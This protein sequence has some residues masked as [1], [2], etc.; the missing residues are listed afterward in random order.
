MKSWR[1]GPKYL[2][3]EQSEQVAQKGGL[4]GPDARQVTAFER[5]IL[6]GLQHKPVY[7]G[8]VD[9]VVVQQRRT[10]NRAGRR[11]RRI[12]RLAAKR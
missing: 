4:A 6:V 8:T 9:P 10:R 5:S 11:S 3:E 1:I 12:N 7:Q 2:T